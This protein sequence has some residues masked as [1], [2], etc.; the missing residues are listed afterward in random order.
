MKKMMLVVVLVQ[1][2]TVVRAQT[3][4]TGSTMPFHISEPGVWASH[5]YSNDHSR[6]GMTIQEFNAQ[7][8]TLDGRRMS[9]SELRKLA[10]GSW[11]CVPETP[12]YS[13]RGQSGDTSSS[14]TSNLS[15][16]EIDSVT[17]EGILD[18]LLLENIGKLENEVA[19]VESLLHV[20]QDLHEKSTQEMSVVA[21]RASKADVWIPILS[22]VIA[23][24]IIIGL[25]IIT[26]YRKLY[27]E[28][29][30]ERKETRDVLEGWVRYLQEQGVPI[31]FAPPVTVLRMLY[32][33]RIAIGKT[34]NHHM[35]HPVPLKTPGFLFQGELA[36]FYAQS[37]GEGEVELPIIGRIKASNHP[38]IFD[39]HRD[40][41][42]ALGIFVQ[43]KPYPNN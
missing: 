40:V 41:A 16:N 33:D 17:I 5:A 31:D 20:Q 30:E 26:Y 4:Q 14:S 1:L 34:A 3:C 8:F 35:I 18:V 12:G 27:K 15:Q 43:D 29:D 2:S 11:I 37:T 32:L 13:Y 24:L 19:R 36:W 21:R 6:M 42:E 7:I 28:A 25:L 23:L 38:T 10:V 9:D 22:G 39:K